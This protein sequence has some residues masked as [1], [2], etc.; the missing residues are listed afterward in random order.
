[1]SLEWERTVAFFGSFIGDNYGLYTYQNSITMST[2]PSTLEHP[3]YA[4]NSGS[5][6]LNKMLSKASPSKAVAGRHGGPSTSVDGKRAASFILPQ[7]KVLS[8][9]DH[10]DDVVVYDCTAFFQGIESRKRDNEFSFNSVRDTCPHWNNKVPLGSFVAVLYSPGQYKT[11]L[12]T[13]SVSLNLMA[14]CILLKED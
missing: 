13:D 4:G 5:T 7:G 14:V 8:T 3:D 1:M 12:G 9:L 11:K 6:S 10:W 2:R